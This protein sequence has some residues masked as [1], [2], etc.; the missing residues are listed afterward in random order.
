MSS[1]SIPLN[2]TLF[3]VSEELSWSPVLVDNSSGSRDKRD[4]RTDW[5]LREA[6]GFFASSVMTAD[7]TFGVRC[8]VNHLYSY[9]AVTRG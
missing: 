7:A 9:W 3:G 8:M 5:A 1:D 2:E 4:W 6:E